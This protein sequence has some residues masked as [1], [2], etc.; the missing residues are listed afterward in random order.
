MFKFWSISLISFILLL[1]VFAGCSK[2]YPEVFFERGE[3]DVLKMKSIQACHGDFKV[4][5]E[6]NFGPFIRAKLKCIK[7]N[8]RG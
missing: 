7:R 3:R 5:E 6:T 1:R 8:V 2:K 4:L